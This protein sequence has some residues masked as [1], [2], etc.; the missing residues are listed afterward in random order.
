MSAPDFAAV[1]RLW[2]E[3]ADAP[4]E[5]RERVLAAAKPA[6]RREVESL[7]AADREAGDFLDAPARRATIESGTRIGP[8][9]LIGLLGS[10]GMGEVYRARD[11]RLGREIALKILAPDLW[12]SASAA[13]R[14]AREARAASAL[15]HPNIVHLYDVATEPTPF[16]AMELVEGG[17]LRQKLTRDSPAQRRSGGP[18]YTVELP[19]LLRALTGAARGLAR[20]HAAGI[21][22]RD[23]KPENIMITP[24]GEAKLLDFGLAKV[25]D[26]ARATSEQSLLTTRAGLVVGT[27]GYMSPEQ[28]QGERVDP[29]S[30]IFSFGC[31][32]FEVA[33]GRRPFESDS[34]IDTLHKI[35]HAPVPSMRQWNAA[36]P[37]R[38]QTLVERCLE[39][40]PEARFQ[41]MEEVAL[42]LEELLRRDEPALTQRRIARWPRAVAAMAVAAVCTLPMRSS[43]PLHASGPVA[44]MP[45]AASRAA[46]A[47]LGDGIAAGVAERLASIDRIE[48]VPNE[49]VREFASQRRALPAGVVV[50]GRL[51]RDGDRLHVTATVGDET[52]AFAGTLSELPRLER[53]V[54]QTVARAL[55]ADLPRGDD[56]AL[57][58]A[59]TSSPRAYDAFLRG[60]FEWNRWTND[61]W[62]RAIAH[63]EEAT[64]A[65][66]L[67]AAAYAGLSDAYAQ[68]A[69]YNAMPPGEAW[70][71]AKAAAL[72][73]L[74]LDPNLGEAHMSLA[75]V[76][77]W[78]EWDLAAAEPGYRRA[79][80]LSPRSPEARLAYALHLGV[81][82]RAAEGVREAQRAVELNPISAIAHRTL[83]DLLQI[84]G[85]HQRYAAHARRFAG[86]HPDDPISRYHLALS[87]QFLGREEEAFD[88]IRRYETLSGTAPAQ[89]AAYEAA[90]RRG[91]MRGYWHAAARAGEAAGDGPIVVAI[92]SA[93]AGDRERTLAAIERGIERHD[94]FILWSRTYPMFAFLRDDPRYQAL[95][96]RLS[97]R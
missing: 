61:G 46:D 78:Y 23:L 13:A 18:H 22:H 47:Y 7:L 31:I 42:A 30:D 79:I 29:R 50:A 26:V 15:N 3:V 5:E 21:V 48:V 93:L 51:E 25:T 1:E 11:P 35:V 70:P 84:V 40:K 19:A 14:F 65:D 74:E 44:V 8:Y 54:A 64:I 67:F 94:A 96:A 62:R 36:L 59:D 45:F 97:P 83:A 32:L 27:I 56:R 92:A 63:F 10:G 85:D 24:G 60:R 55:G 33:A 86:L 53:D 2:N 16:I 77:T 34:L 58:R 43:A 4:A 52:H 41:S 28:A 73:A 87:A 17:T 39:K 72:K 71:K 75:V 38:L 37:R 49:T 76:R 68:L 89:L 57:V 91:G 66:P 6:V 80:A 90:F 9:E 82:G 20:A 12:D 69:L 81:A 95:M 88:H